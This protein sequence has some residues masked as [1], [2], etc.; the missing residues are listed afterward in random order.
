[1]NKF[2]KTVTITLLMASSLWAT[3][4]ITDGSKPNRVEVDFGIGFN[5]FDSASKL[6]HSKGTFYSIKG[7][8]YDS[9][10]DKYGFGLVYEGAY[11]VDYKK[12]DS[13]KKE[14]DVHRLFANLVI[15]GEEEWSIIPYIFM[16]AGYEYLSDEIKGETSQGIADLGIG[17]RYGLDYGLKLGLEGKCI[18]KYDTHD[19][20]Y[21]VGF[22]LGYDFSNTSHSKQLL[23]T[24]TDIQTKTPLQIINETEKSQE[25]PVQTIVNEITV[26]DANHITTTSPVVMPDNTNV[27][28]DNAYY[29]QLAAYRS[30]QPNHMVLKAKRVGFENVEVVEDNDYKGIIRRVLIGPYSSKS[31]ARHDLFK[32]KR[33]ERHAYIIKH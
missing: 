8:I 16:G 25:Q 15:D 6:S 24:Q 4:Y 13:N 21:E 14:T 5:K 10:V 19:L 1:M 9:V 28:V 23:S 26:E 20:D 7:T 12:N 33:V 18:G 27:V 31:E 29:I 3:N 32:A 2:T 11:G 30:A 22:L 17:F